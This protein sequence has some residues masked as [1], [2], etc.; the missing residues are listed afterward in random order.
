VL[1]AIV[2]TSKCDRQQAGRVIEQKLRAI[3]KKYNKV[4]KLQTS[5]QNKMLIIRSLS[6]DYIYLAQTMLAYGRKEF[7]EGIDDIQYKCIIDVLELE[8]E[9]NLFVQ[10]FSPIQDG[11]FGI[12]PMSHLADFLL[13]KALAVSAPFMAQ[14]GLSM[15]Q[16]IIQY[17]SL[18][19][20]WA[21]YFKEAPIGPRV[22][23]TSLA[24]SNFLLDRNNL[25]TW[26]T[27]WPTNKYTTME[28]E[29]YETGVRVRIGK[30][31]PFK[32]FCTLE[33]KELQM[34][35]AEDFTNHIFS[36]VACGT[37]GWKLRH[38]KVLHAA[39]RVCQFYGIYCK[40]N[41]REYPN[42]GNT[43]GGCDALVSTT[44][45]WGVDVAV[46][47]PDHLVTAYNKKL[48]TYEEFEAL[49]TF[50]TFPMIL[51]IH[52]DIYVRTLE[53]L[54]EWK[55]YCGVGNVFL[56][57]FSVIVT[58]E[59]MRGIHHGLVCLAARVSTETEF[60]LLEGDDGKATTPLGLTDAD[61]LSTNLGRSNNN[62]QQKGNGNACMGNGAGTLLSKSSGVALSPRVTPRE[63]KSISRSSD[64][65]LT[66][67]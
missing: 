8:D 29:V 30:L 1:G 11:G 28:D 55:S 54:E 2:S 12:V 23:S 13:Q 22:K 17:S 67:T 58:A 47:K 19:H 14:Y 50:Q 40:A 9:P 62:T 32:H 63:R 45:C 52:G 65:D 25:R 20:A 4:R 46:V 48:E 24:S 26:F 7:F 41:P 21:Q 59:L 18:A 39:A 5:K 56:H 60:V 6:W 10:I 37:H 36:C 49:T 64:G 61:V 27:G 38:E 15:D 51:S 66:V 3:E 42:P 16:G 43:K 33:K 35:S 44:K 31:K 53:L 57:D 34:L